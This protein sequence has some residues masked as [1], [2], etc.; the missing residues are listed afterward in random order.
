LACLTSHRPN[1]LCKGLLD[2]HEASLRL[3]FTDPLGKSY[4]NSAGA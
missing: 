2:E 4:S 1:L 3:I